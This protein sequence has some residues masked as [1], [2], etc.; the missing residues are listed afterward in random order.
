MSPSQRA[1]TELERAGSP[2]LHKRAVPG[3]TVARGRGRTVAASVAARRA[4]ASDVSTMVT[5]GPSTA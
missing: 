3:V 4:T 5:A 2:L 1:A